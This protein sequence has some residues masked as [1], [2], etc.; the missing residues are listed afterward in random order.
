M[1]SSW[2]HR[3]TNDGSERSRKKK[4]T[5]PWWFEKQKILGAKGGSWR[6]KMV[7]MTVL[8]HKH[9]EERQVKASTSPCLIIIIIIAICSENLFKDILKMQVSY[10]K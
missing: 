7:E 4:N 1:L 6:S 3:R 5:A 9:K 2:C 8:S 10:K